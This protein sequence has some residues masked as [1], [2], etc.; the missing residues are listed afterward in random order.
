MA[1]A[2]ARRWAACVYVE[3]RGTGDAGAPAVLLLH[4]LGSSADDWAPQLPLL[5]PCYRVLLV[6]L[7]GH[8]RSALPPGRL[9]VEAMAARV[10]ALLD[11]LGGGGGDGA[12]PRTRAGARIPEGDRRARGLRRAGAAW[13]DPLPDAR[14]GGARRPHG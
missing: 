1:S 8:R 9:T 10:E 13:G 5:T 7:P 2:R 4:G 11:E 14:G 6:D 3:R 12:A